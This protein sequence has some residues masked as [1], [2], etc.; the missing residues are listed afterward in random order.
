MKK[1]LAILLVPLILFSASGCADHL[2]S[3]ISNRVVLQGIG[4]D[5]EEGQYTL[6]IQV[7]NLS[8]ASSSG[9]E[10]NKNVTTLYTT[11]G[12]TISQAANGIRQFI[13]KTRCIPTTG[14]WLSAKRRLIPGCGIF[15][16]ILFGITPPA[17]QS[18]LQ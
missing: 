3:D 11:R 7:F 6:T 8:Q 5:Y 10:T 17:R 18:I 15:W 4:V 14:F 16:I 12:T 9:A 2:N 1:L 13:G